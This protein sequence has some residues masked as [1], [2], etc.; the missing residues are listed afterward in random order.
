MEGE[1]NDV[2]T[3]EDGKI[4]RWREFERERERVPHVIHTSK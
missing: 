3:W 4:V 1:V 2:V